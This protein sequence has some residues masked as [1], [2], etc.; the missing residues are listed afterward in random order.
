MINM[1]SSEKQSATLLSDV[2]SDE[3]EYPYGLRISLDEESLKKLG[4]GEMPEVGTTMALQAKVEVVAV[5]QYEHKDDV[6]RTLV[7]QITDMA[8]DAGSKATQMYPNSNMT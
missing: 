4:I 2:A 1:K 7:L 8:L 6:S 5:S 3:P